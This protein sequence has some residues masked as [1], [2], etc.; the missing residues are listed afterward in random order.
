MKGAHHSAVF[1]I[2]KA[3]PMVQDWKVIG[4][5]IFWEFSYRFMIKL[6]EPH[7]SNFLFLEWFK[8]EHWA[9]GNKIIIPVDGLVDISY[10]KH[11]GLAKACQI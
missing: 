11:K 7:A 10:D 1:K 3:S 4:L 8:F 6:M 5:T 2:I 9:P